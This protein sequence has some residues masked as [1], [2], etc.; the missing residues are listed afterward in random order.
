MKNDRKNEE[1]N[2]KGNIFILHG[3]K[4]PF[5]FKICTIKRILF[6]ERYLIA[7]MKY[8]IKWYNKVYLIEIWNFIHF[9][10][11]YSITGE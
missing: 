5:M 11:R 6:K 1:G 8:S 9:V 10:A 4:L 3:N 2:L 7:K